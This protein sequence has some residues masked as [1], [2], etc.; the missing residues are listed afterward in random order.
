MNDKILNISYI[1]KAVDQV[2]TDL[3]LPGEFLTQSEKLAKI[4][5]KDNDVYEHLMKLI[6][7]GTADSDLDGIFHA[8]RDTLFIMIDTL[9]AR[10]LVLQ[11][12]KR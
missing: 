8:I 11:Y 4:K 9:Q 2:L 12:R 3:K 5:S 6:D 7:K 10:Q 1:E